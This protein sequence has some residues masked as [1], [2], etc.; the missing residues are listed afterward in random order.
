VDLR[1]LNME[2][3]HI[4]AYKWALRMSSIKYFLISISD[5]QIHKLLTMRLR[6]RA[7]DFLKKK[8]VDE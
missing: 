8:P 6:M 5:A 4:Y 1:G 7:F 2:N 3:P